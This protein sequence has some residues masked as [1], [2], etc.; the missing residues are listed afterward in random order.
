MYCGGKARGNCR[1]TLSLSQLSRQ[2]SLYPCCERDTYERERA[3]RTELERRANEQ[4][5]QKAGYTL[6]A[7]DSKLDA[8]ANGRLKELLQNF[9]SKRPDGGTLTELLQK[10]SVPFL[11]SS[12]G[13][14]RGFAPPAKAVASFKTSGHEIIH[15]DGYLRAGVAMG[16]DGKGKLY[17][18]VIV[19]M[20]TNA[21]TF[22]GEHAAAKKGPVCPPLRTRP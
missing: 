5:R 22:S 12:Q 13:F 21:E 4:E 17:Y 6:L 14:G 1:P 18:A 16:D 19:S 10:H 7:A 11:I 9:S 8:A 3:R 15:R 2:W 20:P